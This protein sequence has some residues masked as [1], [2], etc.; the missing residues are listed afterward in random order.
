MMGFII[1]MKLTFN[2][3]ARTVT[4][5]CYLIE[6][7]NQKILVDCGL[8][9]GLKEVTIHNQEGF[10]FNP[11]E[12][13]HVLLTHAHIDHSGLLP[14]L[15][16]D[17]FKGKI[18]CTKATRALCDIML[19]DSA[20]VQEVNSKETGD[21]PLYNELDAKRA[22]TRFKEI[23][24]GDQIDITKNIKARFRD[25][26]HILGASII[27]V[28]VDDHGVKKK[29]TFSGDI[30]Q[31]DMPIVRDPEV[32]EE[33]DYLIL[34]STYGNRLHEKGYEK[35]E[36]IAKV[37]NHANKKGGKLFVPSFA[38][39]RTQELLYRLRELL[40]E[41]KIPPQEVYLDSPLAIRA[42]EVFRRYREFYDEEAKSE[43]NPF[44]FKGLNFTLS[45]NESKVL[46]KMNGP[47]IIIAG[48]G[49]C[50]AGRIL[51]HF[52]NGIDDPANTILF[53]GYMA[54]GTLGRE[55]KEG[56][57]RAKIFKRT[58]PVKA[59]IFTID[60][61]SGHAD[62]EGLLEWVDAFK[63]KPRTVFLTHGEEEASLAM[64]EKI[65]KMGLLAKVPEIYETIEL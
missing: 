42:T 27:E 53:V 64:K 8:F 7:N 59:E 39:E 58:L 49:M 10:K 6:T 3:A 29:L 9:Q 23:E 35:N 13:D 46:N 34:E 38:V 1:N 40:E 50:T 43:K 63:K 28:F 45:S 22:M 19:K 16:K 14:R 32:I 51:H 37:I 5:S 20:H 26:G 61:L 36:V 33:T 17:G 25:A 31:K 4:G 24:Y 12:I 56:A 54:E 48:S 52:N 44:S 55:L 60:S 62:Y 30:G 65:E 21:A 11:S 18:Y 41:K 47:M 2:G 15:V 57:S